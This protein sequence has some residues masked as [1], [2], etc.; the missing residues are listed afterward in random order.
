MKTLSSALGKLNTDGE[1]PI[2]PL[3]LPREILTAAD[4]FME[5]VVVAD[6]VR[7]LKKIE[8]ID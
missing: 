6:A 2:R 1:R 7:N 8:E 5:L 4:K 3:T